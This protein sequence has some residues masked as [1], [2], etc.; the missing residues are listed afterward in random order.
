[1]KKTYF[2]IPAIA[3]VAILGASAAYA[4]GGPGFFMA[5]TDPVTMANNWEAKIQQE[6]N[7]LGISLDE[8]KTDWAAGKTILDIAKEKGISQADLRTRQKNA[9]LDQMKQWLQAL[10]S[11]GKI[12]QAQADARLKAI[13]A[14]SASGGKVFGRHGL[15]MMGQKPTTT[16]QPKVENN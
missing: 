14:K 16:T 3:L 7:L 5:K 10:V 15:R 4:Y 12:T 1:M 11:Q 6:A 8:M 2:L 9:Q 13:Q